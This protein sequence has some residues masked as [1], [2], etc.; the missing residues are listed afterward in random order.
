MCLCIAQCIVWKHTFKFTPFDIF[1][2]KLCF[3]GA[4]EISYDI[5]ENPSNNLET[6]KTRFRYFRY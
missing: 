4:N 3:Q 2:S 5:E 1:I 6:E